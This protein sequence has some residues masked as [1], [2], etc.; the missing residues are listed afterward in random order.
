MPDSAAKT[1]KVLVISAHVGAGHGQAARAV[2]ERLKGDDR[3]VASHVETLDF[4]PA[5]FRWY[6]NGG[7]VFGMTKAPW[8]YGLGFRISDR[9]DG[10]GFTI[11]ERLRIRLERSFLHRL[12]EHIVQEQPDL[13][14]SSHF[15]SPPIVNHLNAVGR[16]RVPQMVI[17][18]DNCMH[19]W[20]YSPGVDHWFVPAAGDRDRLG[21]W[22]VGADKVTVSGIP[23]HP[24][25]ITPIDRDRVLAEWRLPRDKKIVL[26]SGGTEFTVGPVEQTALGILAACPQAFVVVL[27]GRNKDLLGRLGA[28]AQA[29]DRLM[30][31][32]FTDRSQE[33]VE[34][35]SMMVTKPGGI[36]T[37]EC[38][39]RGT[40]M[41]LLKPV[42]GQEGSNA[43][44]FSS[45]GAA[46]VTTGPADVI[47]Q[48]S[49]LLN[50]PH[51]LAAMA[52]AARG[53]YRPAGET[54]ADHIRGF[55][56]RDQ[57]RLQG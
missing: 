53:L 8:L 30:P 50:D 11:N 2:L 24:K 23:V 33:L 39:A 19:R 29:N 34:V 36:T 9:P 32:S 51:C 6:Y 1:K 42:P 37:A 25:W 10:P 46:V 26:L 45:H 55:V 56:C 21:R 3:L 44:F 5:L 28:L 54:I 22:G 14:V 49:S 52:A 17:V 43:R 16:L 13:I 18:T 41:V 47:A 38:L 35:C 27:A 31:V 4:A 7:F 48:V 12:A 40:P 20:W 57:M 15:L